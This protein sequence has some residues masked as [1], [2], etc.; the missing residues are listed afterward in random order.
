MTGT[1]LRL[2][3]LI[4]IGLK[5]EAEVVGWIPWCVLRTSDRHP[6]SADI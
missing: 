6:H 1:S 2:Q 4:K 3:S 5:H